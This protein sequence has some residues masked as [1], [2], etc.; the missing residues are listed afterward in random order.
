MQAVQGF[1]LNLGNSPNELYF[2]ETEINISVVSKSLYQVALS[3]YW[4][5]VLTDPHPAGYL[6]K[7][8]M[9]VKDYDQNFNRDPSN[10]LA[11]IDLANPE[12]IVVEDKSIHQHMRPKNNH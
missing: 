11:K 9:D 5:T 2:Y 6:E 7:L 12:R 8:N 10:L 4:S 1:F 3:T